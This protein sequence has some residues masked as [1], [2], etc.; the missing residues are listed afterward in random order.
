[1]L[2]KKR[3]QENRENW[4]VI[5]VILAGTGLRFWGL[6]RL[7]LWCDEAEAVFL[8][9][10]SVKEMLEFIIRQDAHPPLFYLLVNAMLKAGNTDVWLRLLPAVAGSLC[11]PAVWFFARECAGKKEAFWLTL[12]VAFSPVHILWSQVVKSYTLFTLVGVVTSLAFLYSLKENSRHFKLPLGVGDILLVYLHNYAFLF[13]TGQFLTLLFLKKLDRKWLVFFTFIGIFW[14]PWLVFLPNQIAYTWGIVRRIPQLWRWPYFFF[15]TIFGETTSP[16]QLK[17]VIPVAVV[18][19]VTWVLGFWRM[20]LLPDYFRVFLLTFLFVP[21][22]VIPFRSTVPQNLVPFTI[23]WYLLLAMGI[24]IEKIKVPLVLGILGSMLVSVCFYYQG[25]VEQFHDVSRLA[26]FRKVGE[27]LTERSAV[28]DI[29][30]TNEER[31]WVGNKPFSIFDRYYQGK[32]VVLAV[33][34]ENAPLEGFKK[35]LS[36]YRRVWLLQIHAGEE[37]WNKS[38]VEYLKQNFDLQEKWEYLRN[39]RWLERILTGEKKYYFYL[40]LYF[41]TRREK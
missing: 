14:L 35:A 1:M 13:L 29:I 26:P 32:A 5:F 31:K 21:L 8:G 9:S 22:A 10:L 11:L 7:S 19:T 33:R 6:G 3:W 12:F 23:F 18:V 15:Y 38:L 28:D 27:F 24:Q 17:V 4:Y 2:L 37:E 41:F 16:F 36:G 25:A 40:T 20:R 34:P 39:E 30:I